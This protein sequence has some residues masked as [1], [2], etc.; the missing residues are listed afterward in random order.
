MKKNPA[1]ELLKQNYR[2]ILGNHLDGVIHNLNSPL[3]NIIGYSLLAKKKHPQVQEIDKILA[4]AD[5]INVILKQLNSALDLYQIEE[6]QYVSLTELAQNELQVLEHSL[7][8]K[9]KVDIDF[10][11]PDSQ[12]KIWVVY[13]DF[14]IAFSLIFDIIRLILAKEDEKKATIFINDDAT[15]IQLNFQVSEKNSFSHQE[16]NNYQEKLSQTEY[17]LTHLLHGYEAS[18]FFRKISNTFVFTLQIPKGV[19]QCQIPK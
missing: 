5:R 16:E 15:N 19:N 7:F 10:Q 2:S 17:A 12:T 18:F 11:K 8:Y 9:H 6:K 1:I 3:N 14:A 13:R 4:S